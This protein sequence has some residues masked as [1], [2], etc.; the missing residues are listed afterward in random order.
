MWVSITDEKGGKLFVNKG[1][2]GERGLELMRA[3]RAPV[4]H[5]KTF[6]IP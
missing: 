2:V 4:G 6:S 3:L 1:A 5:K